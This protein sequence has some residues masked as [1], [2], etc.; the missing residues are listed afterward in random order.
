MKRLILDHPFSLK[1]LYVA[2]HSDDTK[3]WKECTLKERINIKVDHLAKKALL[4]AHASN[5][6]FD[7]SFPLEDFQVCTDGRKLTGPTKAHLE[8]HWGR[9]EAKRFFD[10]KGIVQSSKF[11][12]IWWTG[13]HRAIASYPKMFRI[14]ISK[15]VSGWCGSNSKL[16]L[17][18][19]SVENTCPNCGLIN[20]TSKHMTRC[21]HEGRE[22]LLRES[23]QEV[24]ECLEQ[25][26]TDPDLTTMIERYLSAQ[27][28][29]TMES[30]IKTG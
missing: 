8:E 10:I 9:V 7:G 18:D 12:S 5:Q 20:K 17:W 23:I 11:D 21:T 24:T 30:C 15:Q 29:R 6:F 16:L 3:Q 13:L 28:T 25:A 1:F 19:S 4:A 2:S 14:F 26:N 22:T 27:G